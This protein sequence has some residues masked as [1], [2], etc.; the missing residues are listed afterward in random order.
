MRVFEIAAVQARLTYNRLA[1]NDPQGRFFVL[2]EE[3]EQV[4]TLDEYLAKVESG[5]ICPEPL[6]LGPTQETAWRCG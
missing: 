1:G 2:K 4:G 5:E 6:V 3:I